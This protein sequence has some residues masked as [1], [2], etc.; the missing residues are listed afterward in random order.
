MRTAGLNGNGLTNGKFAG[1]QASRQV[2][3]YLSVFGNYTAV[4]Q[5]SNLVSTAN[6]L[7]NVFQS[8][9]FGIGYSPREIRLEK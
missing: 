9:S 6:V 4:S 3:R 8:V 7:N 2:G 1:V 5:S